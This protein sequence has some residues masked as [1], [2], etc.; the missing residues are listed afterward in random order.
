[1]ENAAEKLVQLENEYMDETHLFPCGRS[2][3]L[4]MANDDIEYRHRAGAFSIWRQLK[5][6]R[7][8]LARVKAEKQRLTE[9][10][11]KHASELV[12]AGQ[13][14]AALKA[15]RDRLRK[16]LEHYAFRENW[17]HGEPDDECQTLYVIVRDGFWMA[18]QVL[19]SCTTL[20]GGNDDDPKDSGSGESSLNGG[21]PSICGFTVGLRGFT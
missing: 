13:E 3:P 12:K 4:E 16:G 5:E 14:M 2:V 21:N 18:E 1:M 20:E 7:E 19:S 17:T 9:K 11:T 10:I 6:V 15:D 8:E